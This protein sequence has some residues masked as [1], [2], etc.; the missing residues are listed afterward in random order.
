MKRY[1]PHCAGFITIY[2][3]AAISLLDTLYTV[4][5]FITGR[6]NSMM[7]GFSI[8][9]ILIFISVIAYLR[10]YAPTKVEVDDKKLH[11]VFP[12]QIRPPEGTKRAM[13]LYR[14]GDLD[15]HQ[16]DKTIALDSIVRYGYVED[17]GY[18]RL[19]KSLVDERNKFLPVHEVAFITKEKKRYHMNAG[20]YNQKQLRAMFA[21][22]RRGTGLAPEGKLAEL[23]GDA[24]NS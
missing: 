20:F 21:D 18:D 8:F 1:R 16:V 7:S 3:L 23:T 9:G 2:V 12:T 19:D 17:L 6:T 11:I 22:I 5:T 24:P 15:L 10:M 13:I 4:F 14:Q